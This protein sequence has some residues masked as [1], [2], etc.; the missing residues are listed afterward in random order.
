MQKQVI[1]Q[2]D[3]YYTYFV[4]LLCIFCRFTQ[5][6]CN[7]AAIFINLPLFPLKKQANVCKSLYRLGQHQR[8]SSNFR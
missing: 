6:S 3:E 7:S 1:K 4:V 2:W 5:I 8:Q